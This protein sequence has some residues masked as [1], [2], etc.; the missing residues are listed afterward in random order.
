MKYNLG[1]GRD[2]REGWANIDFGVQFKADFREDICYLP[3]AKPNTASIIELCAVLEHI[4]CWLIYEAFNRWYEI[5]KEGCIL[6]IHGLPDFDQLIKLYQEGKLSLGIDEKK[7]NIERWVHG[8][9]G[10]TKNNWGNYNQL[11]KALWNK[12]RVERV[13]KVTNWTLQFMQ[14]MK[15]RNEPW[16]V[17]LSFLATKGKDKV[18]KEIFIKRVAAWQS[19]RRDG[20]RKEA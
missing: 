1:C 15:Y 16:D 11:H 18:P 17:N 2:Y 10:D 7:Q 3:S 4:P 13:L 12:P 6:S 14:N 8:C 20:V 9:P 19:E 5:G